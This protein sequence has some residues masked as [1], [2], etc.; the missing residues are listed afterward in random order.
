MLSRV[1]VTLHPWRDVGVDGFFICVMI[2]LLDMSW[3]LAWL[4]SVEDEF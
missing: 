1:N 2:L 4:G 3:G